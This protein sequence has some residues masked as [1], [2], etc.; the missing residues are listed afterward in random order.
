MVRNKT[1]DAVAYCDVHSKLLYA[2]RKTARAVARKHHED[3]KSV[4]RCSVQEHLFHVGAL[5]PEVKHGD[6]SRADMRRQAS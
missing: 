5:W 2:D 1:A 3:R 6:L 4:Y